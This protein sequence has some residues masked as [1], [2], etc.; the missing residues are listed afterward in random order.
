M[1]CIIYK[2]HNRI[3]HSLYFNLARFFVALA[4]STYLGK[5]TKMES[6]RV[7]HNLNPCD[8]YLLNI[9]NISNTKGLPIFT[10]FKLKFYIIRFQ[11][12]YQALFIKQNWIII[13]VVF[14]DFFFGDFL[15]IF[16]H[17]I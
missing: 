3:M 6:L 2:L 11:K 17:Y 5:V 12:I 8:K 1:P 15:T 9:K 7:R 4:H 10:I 13:H 14:S 16:L